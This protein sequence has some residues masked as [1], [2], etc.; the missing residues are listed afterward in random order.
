MF[1]PSENSCTVSR[2]QRRSKDENVEG[3]I[4]VLHRSDRMLDAGGSGIKHS[5][6]YTLTS[7][8]WYVLRVTVGHTPRIPSMAHLKAAE[9]L[10]KSADLPASK[11][12]RLHISPQP[13]PAVDSSFLLGTAAQVR[14][15][16]WLSLQILIL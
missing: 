1:R 10:W 11:L 14:F 4:L 6:V 13:D 3:A 8:T 2:L 15:C 7:L 16:H 5:H 9:A 12:S